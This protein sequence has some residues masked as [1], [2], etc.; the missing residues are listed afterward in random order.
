MLTSE[1]ILR[2]ESDGHLAVTDKVLPADEIVYV[3]DRIDRLFDNI[4]ERFQS[5]WLQGPP[6][7][8]RR[9]YWQRS[10]GSVPSTR[11][12]R[13]PSWSEPATRLL[14]RSWAATYGVDSTVRSTN[15]P[16]RGPSI[17]TRTIHFQRSAS[18]SALCTSGSPLTTTRATPELWS[19]HRDLITAPSRRTNSFLL[20]RCLPRSP[21]PTARLRLR[22]RLRPRPRLRPRLRPRP[23]PRL[24]PYGR[25][26]CPSRS[27][28]FRYT[29]PGPGTARVQI[30]VGTS[31]RRCSLN[32]ARVLGPPLAN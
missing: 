7:T 14:L 21:S 13:T 22:L 8:A 30:R 1:Q 15:I 6:M 26:A 11:A 16:V 4:G 10:T 12:L 32:T 31:V 23:R 27:A 28:I 5:V 25:S 20:K 29:R 3:R 19:L 24:R 2:Y 17:G 9:P 18:R